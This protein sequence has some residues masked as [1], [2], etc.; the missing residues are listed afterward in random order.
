M[1]QDGLVQERAMTQGSWLQ[2]P[3]HL[4]GHRGPDLSILRKY[5][6]GS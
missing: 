4:Q 3:G 5:P 1:G 2:G 6:A